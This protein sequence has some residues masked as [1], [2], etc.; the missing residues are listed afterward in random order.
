ML[1]GRLTVRTANYVYSFR[2]LLG[3]I[4]IARASSEIAVLA[5]FAA[6]LA[7][8]ASGAGVSGKTSGWETVGCGVSAPCCDTESET[9]ESEAS[10]PAFWRPCCCMADIA[11]RSFS[12]RMISLRLRMISFPLAVLGGSAGTACRALK[13]KLATLF[14]SFPGHRRCMIP[15]L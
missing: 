9:P 3:G 13:N 7:L 10:V 5:R 1:N 8:R 11:P 4:G 15:C 12:R 6:V 14:S 2:R